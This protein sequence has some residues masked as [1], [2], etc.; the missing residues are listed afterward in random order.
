MQRARRKG[1]LWL[2]GVFLGKE[3]LDGLLMRMW[4][5]KPGAAE[6][7][8]NLVLTLSSPT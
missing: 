6:G 3:I 7:R 4:V 8:G 5:R 1:A 2:E